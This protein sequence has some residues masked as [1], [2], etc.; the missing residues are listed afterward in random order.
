MLHL[1]REAIRKRTKVF[2]VEGAP[3]DPD[4]ADLLAG[5]GI[6]VVAGRSL[7]KEFFRYAG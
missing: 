7:E 2:W 3:V 1:A 6:Q 5:Q 4:V